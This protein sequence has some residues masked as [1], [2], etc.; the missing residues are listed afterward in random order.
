MRVVVVLAL[1]AMVALILALVT[2]STWPALAVITLAVAGIVLLVREWRSDRSAR[3]Q[4]S[5]EGTSEAPADNAPI[6]PEEF[7]PDISTDPAGP[8]SDARAD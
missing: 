5:T 1:A 3:D 2:G 4:P 6:R 7:S 8:S